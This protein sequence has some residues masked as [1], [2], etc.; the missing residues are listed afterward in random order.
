MKYL[1]IFYSIASYL[2]GLAALAC[3]ILFIGDL[4]LPVTI[5]HASLI[6]PRLEG[7]SA[8][9]AN[10]ALVAIWGL[11]HSIMADPMFKRVWTNIV[12]TS[13]ER[14]TYVLTTGIFTIALMALWSPMPGTLWDLGTGLTAMIVWVGFWSGWSITVLST[15][16]INHFHLFGL[17]QA[18][19]RLKAMPPKNE[20]FVTPLLYKLVRHP[21]MTGI[22]I[23]I[24]CA[25]TMSEGR[26]FFS[27]A[28]TA[29]IILG[30]Q[31]GEER[32][33]SDFGFEYE[34]FKKRVP[35]LVP[36]RTSNSDV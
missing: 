18:W 29:Y 1:T 24:W 5:N 30:P 32:L 3:L 22:I 33:T 36:Q 7:I 21:M 13:I 2:V 4:Y 19:Q 9:I 14:S 23:A 27:L 16:L 26:F 34:Q 17:E 28:M 25:P 12:A 15:F 11:Q 6:S 10:L 8:V 31:H 35:K 20:T